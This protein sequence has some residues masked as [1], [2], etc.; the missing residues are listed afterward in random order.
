MVL[1]S[2]ASPTYLTPKKV[3][4]TYYISGDIVAGSPAFYA[5][6]HAWEKMG[7][8]PE[9]FRILSVGAFDVHPE[10]ISSKTGLIAW[11]TKLAKLGGPVK[12]R[13]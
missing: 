9:N 6:L 5:Y 1:A 4:D 2:A 10:R 8:D 7:K 13:T 11:L 12:K 3:G